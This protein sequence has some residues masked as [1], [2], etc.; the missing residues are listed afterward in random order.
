MGR[1][2]IE[3]EINLVLKDR[4]IGGRREV[5]GLGRDW[6]QELRDAC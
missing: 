4:Y 2:L 5:K 6:A 1:G 3:I